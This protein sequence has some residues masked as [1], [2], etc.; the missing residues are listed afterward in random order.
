[1]ATINEEP[2]F[3]EEVNVWRDEATGEIKSEKVNKP[4]PNYVPKA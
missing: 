1:L 2:E 3:F 4:N